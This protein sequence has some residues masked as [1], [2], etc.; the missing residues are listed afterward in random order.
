MSDDYNSQ[1]GGV[2]FHSL[3]LLILPHGCFLLC[4]VALNCELFIVVS[5]KN[6]LW[7]FFESWNKGTFFQKTYDFA[8]ALDHLKL[9]FDV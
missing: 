1:F 2:C 3:F 9:K 7:D 6:Y 4:L 8:S 5:S